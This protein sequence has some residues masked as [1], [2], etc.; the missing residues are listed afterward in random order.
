[1]ILLDLNA[2]K[3]SQRAYWAQVRLPDL[4]RNIACERITL[5]LIHSCEF[6]E[7]G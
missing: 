2:S 1:M 7:F 5:R 6:G 4:G 3:S